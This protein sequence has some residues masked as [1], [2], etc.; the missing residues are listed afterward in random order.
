MYMYT[1]IF[2]SFVFFFVVFSFL[3]CLFLVVGAQPQRQ[4]ISTCTYNF[5]LVKLR[6][7][8]S[9]TL[10]NNSINAINI[11]GIIVI[12]LVRIIVVIINSNNNSNNNNSTRKSNC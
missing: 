5:T 3:C 12:I 4:A 9:L 8:N 6:L 2:G 11:S 1:Y 7:A 10:Y